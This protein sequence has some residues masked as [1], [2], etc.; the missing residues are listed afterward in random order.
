MWWI[1]RR[2]RISADESL[3]RIPDIRSLRSGW[4]SVSVKLTLSGNVLQKNRW[5]WKAILVWRVLPR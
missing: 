5:L 4:V 2:N 1:M 3:P